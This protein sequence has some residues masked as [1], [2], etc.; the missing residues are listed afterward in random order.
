M[1]T[2]HPTIAAST[3]WTRVTRA[4]IAHQISGLLC[5]VA[6]AA[7]ATVCASARSLAVRLLTCATADAW[8]AASVDTLTVHH[9]RSGQSS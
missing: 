9:L 6:A 7:L 4:A 1:R 5:A 2:L 8:Y 3:A